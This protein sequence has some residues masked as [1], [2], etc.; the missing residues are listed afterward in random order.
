MDK[1]FRQRIEQALA[2]KI[3]E[4]ERKVL[5]RLLQDGAME[6]FL[7]QETERPLSTE[8]TEG[9]NPERLAG[10]KAYIQT[11][12]EKIIH[13]HKPTWSRAWIA[14]AATIV[15]AV[16]VGTWF[17]RPGYFEWNF[18]TQEEKFVT[19]TGGEYVRIPDGSS[20]LLD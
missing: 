10:I 19:G 20:A 6:D 14:V 12:E 5:E 16:T 18:L 1:T 2:G 15:I 17:Y 11:H 9:L 8:A 4:T 7:D 3:S 13:I